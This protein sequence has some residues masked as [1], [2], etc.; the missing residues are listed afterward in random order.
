MNS[1]RGHGSGRLVPQHGRARRLRSMKG[2]RPLSSTTLAADT[3]SRR[4][5]PV[6]RE[7]GDEFILT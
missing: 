1:D 4:A 5:D 6:K 3:E 2:Q 7:Y